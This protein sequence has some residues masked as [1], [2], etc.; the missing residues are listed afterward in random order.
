[1]QTLLFVSAPLLPAVFGL[2]CG[3]AP[4]FRGRKARHAWVTLGLVA[5]FGLTLAL[6]AT[7]DGSVTLFTL[8]ATIPIIARS[9]ALSR[10]FAVLV[11]GMWLVA[12]VYS[13]GYLE[14]DSA[15]RR[16]FLFY[17]LTEGALLALC[18]AGTMVTMYLCF[19]TMTL[20][21]VALVLHNRTR[22]AVAAGL[23]Y[24]LYSI[25]GAMM[26]LF[27][28]FYL[29]EHAAA[30]EFMPGG[31]LTAETLRRDGGTLLWVLLVTLIGF[32]TKA[33]LFPM[34]GWLPTAHPAAP[35]PASAVLSGVIVKSGVLCVLRILYYVAGP[36]VFAGTWLQTVLLALALVTVFMGSM[37]ALLENN[38]KKR[39]AY[40]TVSQI[41]YILFGLFLCD[42]QAMSGALMHVWFHSILKTALFLCAGAIL[43][44]TG[45]AGVDGLTGVGKRMPVTLWCFTLAGVGLIGIP[46]LAGFLSKWYLARGALEGGL[47]VFSWLGPV[48]LL[49]SALLTAGYLLPVSTAAFFPGMG[50]DA[51][52]TAFPRGEAGAAMRWPMLLLAALALLA[53]LWPAPLMR[54][55]DAI[56]R[57]LL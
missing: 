9:D 48:V 35:A 56:V 43:V 13:F 20:C 47:A 41:S 45:R 44:Q 42:A 29:T 24:L 30:A 11:S 17:F 25:A 15:P 34:H 14:H 50:K 22:E 57:P 33:G 12:G 18:F 26:G 27:G 19:E 7:G 2:L 10:L 28:I 55:V 3:L 23:K 54:A 21:S 5:A 6:C 1:M 31:I 39:L 49:V 16:Y 46:P 32:G 8:G 38:L 37:L 4:A 36:E 40:S 52:A 51:L 53:G